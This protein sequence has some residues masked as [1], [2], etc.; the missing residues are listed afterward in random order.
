MNYHPHHYH[1]GTHAVGITSST[2]ARDIIGSAVAT[3]TAA[4]GTTCAH[5]R[6]HQRHH[7]PTQRQEPGITNR[8]NVDTTSTTITGRGLP[9]VQGELCSTTINQYTTHNTPTV[10]RGVPYATHHNNTYRSST[11]SHGAS[12]GPP[13][14]HIRTHSTWVAG[15][16]SPPRGRAVGAGGAPDPR[17]PSERRK[18]PPPGTLFRRPHG[19]QRWPARAHPVGPVLTP[20]TRTD[21]IR[22]IRVAEPRLPAP[23][24]GRPGEGQRLTPDAPQNGG[25]PPPPGTAPHHPPGKQPPQGMQAKGTVLGRHT[26]TPAPTARG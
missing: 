2:L 9:T 26:C 19:A 11:V 1:Q 12:A 4:H 22:D 5:H 25:R 6:P 8:I 14:P 20:H 16:D 17:R 3:G 15:S 13:H 24:D 21:R 10:A 7:H 18:A 23:E